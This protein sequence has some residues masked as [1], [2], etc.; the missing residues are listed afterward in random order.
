MPESP[1]SRWWRVDFEAR[2]WA[3]KGFG[4]GDE[5]R[6]PVLWEDEK[7]W[8]KWLRT[9]AKRVDAAVVADPNT[10]RGVGELERAAAR[11]R[12]GA[13]RLPVLFPG[14][15]AVSAD[16]VELILALPPECGE[17]E[18]NDLLY[19]IG[20]PA[21]KRSDPDARADRTWRQ[22]FRS[23]A[24]R[25]SILSMIRSPAPK[26]ALQQAH[27][28]L[29][30]SGA[31][32]AGGPPAVHGSRARRLAS[33]GRSFTW[34]KMTRPRAEGLRLALLDGKGSLIAAPEGASLQDPNR[35]PP[36]FIESITIRGARYM[37][38]KAAMRIPFSPR[39]TAIIGGRGTGKS[40]ALDFLRRAFGRERELRDHPS[41][42]EDYKRRMADGSSGEQGLLSP[43]TR[44]AVHLLKDGVRFALRWAEDLTPGGVFRL[45]E[46]GGE[47]REEG[48]VDRRFPVRI[49]G[50]KQL[51]EV[52][53][54]PRALL[55]I[56]DESQEVD[57]QTLRS[58]M[59]EQELEFLSACASARGLRAAAGERATH[60][61]ARDDIVRK[62]EILEASDH[63]NALN[64]YRRHRDLQS[65]LSAARRR[66]KRMVQALLK[67]ADAMTMPDLELDAG[68]RDTP[69]EE[70]L[71]GAHAELRDV[72][73]GLA[74]ALR[75]AARQAERKLKDPAD[76]REWRAQGQQARIAYGDAKRRLADEGIEGGEYAALV[77]RAR[78][79]EEKI[80]ACGE[81]REEARIRE[82]DA[83]GA[84]R[85]YRELRLELSL[86]RR[87]F[88][89]SHS[90]EEV[91]ISVDAWGDGSGARS[92]LEE[93][94]GIVAF[95]R[96]YDALAKAMQP[97]QGRPVHAPLDD[98]ALA[99]GALRRGQEE[100]WAPVDA[101]FRPNVERLPP[102][103]LDRVPLY[104]PGDAISVE[105][106]G[107]GGE[108]TDLG[109][110]SPGQQTAALLAFVL[111]YGE[112]PIVLD[113]PEDDL[114]NSLIYELLVARIR[115]IKPK[116]QIIVVTHN[117]NIVVHGDAE[118]AVSLH[119]PGKETEISAMGGLQ[120][121]RVRDEICR[122]MEGG[123]RAF[124]D[125]Y[126]RIMT[127]TP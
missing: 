77:A 79:L 35:P 118:L 17:E 124:E 65:R 117:P 3:A 62:L 60:E 18:V 34:V 83:R 26:A 102:E 69:G 76:L 95:E 85:R 58:E 48:A 112:E 125:R 21:G 2:T 68:S 80:A 116:R 92:W 103:R 84:L 9:V 53:R 50:Q 119:T 23:L 59:R 115:Q 78:V 109:R 43:E 12:E 91:R 29:A 31:A 39:C 57:A 120:E 121:Q 94:L 15:R 67:R 87:R 89:E 100:A 104:V 44:V 30:D 4:A 108:W 93:T 49:Y 45:D 55:A 41:L 28:Q 33:L 72:A 1:G 74:E 13:Q 24:A 42:W 46:D 114:D 106:R 126:R 27:A 99:L 14:V 40:T 96:D 82:A 51:F 122:V 70:Q 81:A 56:I 36:L 113:Q 64:A 88:A 105:F 71:R 97:V 111:G 75:A 73:R 66:A 123:R 20:L 19:E 38:R 6:E 11:L 101:R 16:G 32:P 90:S 63:T 7:V 98:A 25:P 22:I 107:A 127:Q 110:G 54:D 10:A 8:E 52:A 37:G 5:A 61:A 86:R 47:T